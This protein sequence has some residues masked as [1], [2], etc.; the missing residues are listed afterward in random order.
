[1]PMC[2]RIPALFAGCCQRRKDA[3]PG[4]YGWCGF[5]NTFFWVDPVIEIAAVILM[6]MVPFYDPGC[7]QVYSSFEELVYRNL[8]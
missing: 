7:I 1:M 2:W 5:L 4:S 6:Q 3:S 8:E